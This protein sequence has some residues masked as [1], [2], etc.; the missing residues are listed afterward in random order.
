MNHNPNKVGVGQ[1]VQL[2]NSEYPVKVFELTPQQ[3]FARVGNYPTDID[4]WEVMT[5]R[6]TPID[7]N[8]YFEKIYEKIVEESR[9]NLTAKEY[10]ELIALEYVLTWRYTEKLEEDTQ[11]YMHLSQKR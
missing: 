11:R 10:K 6:L 1:W 2:D 5:Y 7:Y 4:T 8:E 3:M 9:G